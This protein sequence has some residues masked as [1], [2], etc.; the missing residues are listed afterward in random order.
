M[1]VPSTYLELQFQDQVHQQT[2]LHALKDTD[3]LQRSQVNL[4][5][6]EWNDINCLSYLQLCISNESI[7]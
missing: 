3:V 5:M 1:M 2:R 6:C 7:R 4:H